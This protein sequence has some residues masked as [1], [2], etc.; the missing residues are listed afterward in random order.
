[1]KSAIQ[2]NRSV[3]FLS[4]NDFKDKSIQV[5]RKTP[6]AFAAAG[7][8]VVYIVARDYSKAGNYYYEKE[9]NPE[10]IEV[11]RFPMPLSWFR[12][13][14]RWHFLQTLF[15]QLAGWL[16][17]FR[18]ARRARKYMKNANAKFDVIYGYE[19]HGVCAVAWLGFWGRLG[20]IKVIS[21]FQGTWMAK[22]IREKNWLKRLLNIDDVIALKSRADLCIMTNDGTEG[23]FA[24]KKLRSRALHNL[25]F[26]I[27][28]VDEQKLSAEHFA[29]LKNK[30]NPDG[31]KRVVLSVSRMEQWKRVDRIIDVISYL[32]KELGYMD[33]LYIGVGEGALLKQYQQEVL[34][35]GMEKFIVFTG[36]VP[37]SEVNKY[38]NL[39]DVFISTYDL[40]NVGNPLLEAIRANKIIFTLNNGTTKEWIEHGRN[41]F[42]YN[43]D[44]HLI[45]NMA[46]DMLRVCNDA[47][48]RKHILSEIAAT[49]HEK[50]WSWEQR[51]AAELDAVEKLFVTNEQ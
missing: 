25:K 4:A 43:V 19:V 46:K 20:N 51:F 2:N 3:L 7:W 30:Y 28:G 14:I 8:N 1:M 6:E 24:M 9:I 50:L 27:N 36:G 10:G 21:R 47:D 38:L 13:N 18:L 44:N 15:S 34:T 32:V 11:I 31:S 17:I 22:Y 42:I 16:T 37:N 23:D 40:S 33:I 26:W 39:A 48:I 12:N 49:E 45:E 5:I 41:G 35:S 29:D